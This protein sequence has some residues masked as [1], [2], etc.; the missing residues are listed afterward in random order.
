M[1]FPRDLNVNLRQIERNC[2][3]FKEKRN[4]FQ[5]DRAKKGNIAEMQR[6]NELRVDIRNLISPE[7]ETLLKL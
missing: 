3:D 1:L 5:N 2:R 7:R 6:Y 4:E